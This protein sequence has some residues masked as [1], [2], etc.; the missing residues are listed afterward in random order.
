MH[1][2]SDE[3]K[4]CSFHSS[5]VQSPSDLKCSS[6]YRRCKHVCTLSSCRVW[7]FSGTW[8]F[9][10]RLKEESGGKHRKKPSIAYF[11]LGSSFDGIPICRKLLGIAIGISIVPSQS[12]EV[13]RALIRS[14]WRSDGKSYRGVVLLFEGFH[15]Y[16]FF[17]ADAVLRPAHTTPGRLAPAIGDWEWLESLPLVEEWEAALPRSEGLRCGRSSRLPTKILGGIPREAAL[18]QVRLTV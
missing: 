17:G 8:S 6:A 16:L 14:M 2:W 3:A 15:L 4:W 11:C 9:F 13:P 12:T 7:L 1:W 10:K 5:T 18:G